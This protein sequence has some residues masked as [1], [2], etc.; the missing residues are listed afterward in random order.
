MDKEM[1]KEINSNAIKCGPTR[2]PA[3]A[4]LRATGINDEDF[5]K[6]FIAIVNTWSTVTPC[7]IHLNLLA[8]PLRQGIRDAGG[9]PV[10][11][12]TIMISDGISMGTE[13]MKAS[14]MSREVIADSIELVVRGH[15]LDAVVVIVGCDKTIPA[16]A[17]AL[18]RLNVPG[19]VF[20][21]GSTAPGKCNSKDITIQDVF[22]GVG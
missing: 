4:M 16:A 19:L 22:E 5:K 2:A 20:Y 10:D 8:E 21:G 15:S 14:L 1:K 13:G 3:R 11:F 18:A 6:P 9:V 12:N 7:N 17:M